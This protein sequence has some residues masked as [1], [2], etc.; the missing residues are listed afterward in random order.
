MVSTLK[1]DSLRKEFTEQLST[2]KVKNVVQPPAKRGL[3]HH[4]EQVQYYCSDTKDD[5]RFMTAWFYVNTNLVDSTSNTELKRF[6]VDCFLDSTNI[7]PKNRAN[8][9]NMI[10]NLKDEKLKKELSIKVKGQ[11]SKA[12][13]EH[14]K[15]QLE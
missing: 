5:C 7:T 11:K 15:A 1:E 9:E 6:I 13:I 10:V 2:V 12:N 4:K 3:V 8:V 14:H